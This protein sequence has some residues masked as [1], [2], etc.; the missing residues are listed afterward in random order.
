M[1][2]LASMKTLNKFWNH[3]PPNLAR[4]LA[5]RLLSTR[6]PPTLSLRLKNPCLRLFL[7][8][9][10]WKVLFINQLD[11]SP[12]RFFSPP[13]NPSAVTET[14]MEVT[15]EVEVLMEG[16]EIWGRLHGIGF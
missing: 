2:P 15:D 9:D 7:I 1:L 5:I 14:F 10:G 3:E 11:K 13:I 12:T 16:N 8:M 4:P 6:L